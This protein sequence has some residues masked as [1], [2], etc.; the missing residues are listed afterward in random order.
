MKT[1]IMI[2]LIT[3]LSFDN[4]GN[5]EKIEYEEIKIMCTQLKGGEYV[6]TNNNDYQQL[7]EIRSPHPDCITYTLPEINFNKYTLIIIHY[8]VGGC[9]SPDVNF[10]IYKNDYGN[11]IVNTQIAQYGLCKIGQ[12]IKK[13]VLIPKIDDNAEVIFEKNVVVKDKDLR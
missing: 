10:N 13:K 9:K 7:L 1:L 8:V 3:L 6:I 5:K 2:C 4:D 11:F 12:H